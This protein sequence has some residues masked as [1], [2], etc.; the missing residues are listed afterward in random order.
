M[1]RRKRR[2]ALQKACNHLSSAI[3]RLQEA[4]AP[5]NILESASI[6]R[7]RVEI[8]AARENSK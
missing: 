7:D 8:Y 5:A 2:K 6:I 4:Q 1:K 3:V